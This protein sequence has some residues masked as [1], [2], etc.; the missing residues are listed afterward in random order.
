MRRDIDRVRSLVAFSVDLGELSVLI[1]RLRELFPSPERCAVSITVSRKSERLI[2]NAVEEISEYGQLQGPVQDFRI[3]VDC[4]GRHLTIA[5]S[6]LMESQATAS[7]TGDSEAWCAGAV[8]TVHAFTLAHK[9]W[10]SALLAFPLGWFFFI[11]TALSV[12]QTF[13]HWAGLTAPSWVSTIL[14]F[15]MSIAM[16]FYFWRKTW[17]PPAVIRI[18]EKESFLKKHAVILTVIFAVLG[19]IGTFGAW[20]FPRTP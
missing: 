16:I 10:Y 20:L 18:T 14:I 4:D 6:A 8:E 9:Q 2:F 7:A 17:F 11:M 12:V 5:S 3:R 19:A 13:A 15:F 1:A